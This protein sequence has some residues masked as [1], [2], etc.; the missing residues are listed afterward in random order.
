[1]AQGNNKIRLFTILSKNFSFL[2]CH[3]KK[4]FH[5]YIGL[6]VIILTADV[7]NLLE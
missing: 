7:F 5:F 3:F 2:F 1:M 4:S 6:S